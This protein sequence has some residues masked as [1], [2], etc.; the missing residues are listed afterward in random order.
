[1]AAKFFQLSYHV[2]LSVLAVP[3]VANFGTGRRNDDKWFLATS[4]WLHNEPQIGCQQNL[5][6]Q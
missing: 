3:L 4:P 1:M 6:Q 2:M 5:E